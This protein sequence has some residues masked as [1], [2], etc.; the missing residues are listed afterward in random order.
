MTI[1]YF[2]NS[3]NLKTYG[4][5]ISKGIG[6][7]GKPKRKKP[8]IFEYPDESGYVADLNSI[9]YE[10]RTI[11]LECFIK[12]NSV[13]DLILLYDNFTT[14][15]QNVG[16]VKT[17]RV[18]INSKDLSYQVYASD[19]ST[20]QKTFANGLNVGT[21]KITFIEPDTSIYE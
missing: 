2:F 1:N 13:D 7:L 9:K 14:D 5:Y 8:N 21:F 20:L 3:V 17:L 19:I 16:D 4:V 18:T 11:E 12:A 10:I 6:L 15:V